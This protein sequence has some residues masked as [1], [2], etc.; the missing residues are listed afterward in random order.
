MNTGFELER[1]ERLLKDIR[2]LIYSKPVCVSSFHIKNGAQADAYREDLHEWQVSPSGSVWIGHDQYRWYQ[3]KILIPDTYNHHFAVF[4]LSTGR[5]GQ[6]D[7]TNPQMLLYVGQKLMQGMDVN[8]SRFLL[9]NHAVPGTEYE[10]AFLAYSGTAGAELVIKARTAILNEE[11]EALYYD[12]S[13][14]VEAARLLHKTDPESNRIILEKMTPA[15]DALDLRVPYSKSFDQSVERARKSLRMEFY[16]QVRENGPVVSGIGHTHIDVAWLWSV[17][18]TKAKV[19]R[20]FATVLKLMEDYP[21]YKFMSSQPI[22]YQFVKESNPPMYQQI[23][24]RIKEGRWEIDGAMWLEPDCNLPCGES[25]VR[26]LL[27]GHIFMEKEF[28]VHSKTLWLPDVFG[29]SAAL[30]QLLK[31]CN[32]SRFLTTKISWNQYNQLPND[33]FLWRGI[34]GSEVFVY[35]PTTCDIDKSLGLN[36]SFSDTGNTTTYTGNINSNMLLGTHDRFQNKDLTTNTLMLFGFGD[37]GGGPTYEML[38]NAKRLKYGLPGVPRFELEK[39]ED[40]LNRTQ[41]SIANLPNMPVWDGELYFEYHRGTYTS[42]AK[43]KRNNRINEILYEKLETLSTLLQ[44]LGRKYP[45]DIINRGWD[46]LLLNQFHDILPGTSI[47]SVYE[48]TDMEYSEIYHAALAEITTGLSFLTDRIPVKQPSLL[49]FNSLGYE[50]SDICAVQF[51]GDF[52]FDAIQTSDGKICPLQFTG[53]NTGIFWADNVPSVGYKTFTFVYGGFGNSGFEN[54]IHI[55]DED[56]TESKQEV[57]PYDPEK[58][59]NKPFCIFENTFYRAVILK[60]LTIASIIEK[61]TG[62]EMILPGGR[63]NQITTYE[64]RPM[65]WDNWDIDLYY[66]QKPYPADLISDAKVVETGPIRLVLENTIRFSGSEIIQQMILY[67][68]LP[69]IDFH[70]N[71][72]WAEHHVLLK[73]GFDIDIHSTKATYEI[74]F[75]S[76]ERETTN[77][78][79]WDKAKFETCAH[80]WA[81]LSDRGCGVSLL[82][83]CKYGHYIKGKRM[84]ITLIKSGTYPNPNADIGCH[85]YT[86]SLYPHAGSCYEANTVQMAY[87]LNVP[88]ET[89]IFDGV[90]GY[91]PA[92]LEFLKTNKKNCFI[93]VLKQAENGKGFII[94]AYENSGCRCKVEFTLA[95]SILQITECNLLEEHIREV[96]TEGKSFI[97]IFNPFEIKTYR[98][99]CRL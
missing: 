82:N 64:D 70:H 73:T 41:N 11:V 77:N 27:K 81:D 44:Q 95:A 78:N 51:S 59:M 71:V 30:P 68:H 4:Q 85:E 36:R 69:R 94:R 84:E 22:L 16:T 25:L 76:I 93:E 66:R 9:T 15:L 23:K 61:G 74:Q 49:V 13:N 88:L 26:Q 7:A 14:P 87:N 99:V 8:H 12:L 91:L 37:G 65:D 58:A 28:G 48:T 1:A 24:D 79:S 55:S 60:D 43:N 80:K 57:F 86:Y 56:L 33:T 6:W 19:I 98:F 31:K 89:Q 29:Y 18:Q 97:D 35:M 52:P 63:G 10:I 53:S 45:A 46:V 32:I 38:E 34:D 54:N 2:T 42:M 62:K 67:H 3:T 20:S 39:E 72:S 21:D 96:E 90:N 5:E 50:R 75:G 40:F 92:T 83:D 47:E 17:E